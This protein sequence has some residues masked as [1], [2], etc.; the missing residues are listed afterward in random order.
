[1]S[2]Y[3][4]G[5]P[6]PSI[7]DLSKFEI[8]FGVNFPGL[9]TLPSPIFPSITMPSIEK[10][11][12]GMEMQLSQFLITIK[13]MVEPMLSLIGGDVAS[14]FPSIPSLPDF[15]LISILQNGVDGV[16][17]KIK[18]LI[19]SGFDFD[20]PLLPTLY[21]TMAIPVVKVLQTFQFIMRN[22]LVV[23]IMKI[24]NLIKQV[25]DHLEIGAAVFPSIPTPEE[26][27]A[28]MGSVIDSSIEKI[29][30]FVIYVKKHGMNAWEF[31][32]KLSFPGLPSMPET[33]GIPFDFK[34][35]E[36]TIVSDISNFLSN[37]CLGVLRKIMEFIDSTLKNYMTFTFPTICI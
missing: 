28:M 29:D 11:V 33:P 23:I 21:P 32:S 19:D 4:F 17:N 9:P 36:I 35:P 26:I 8:P 20:L 24:V 2:F 15:N 13:A 31:L 34:I 10:F 7:P 27:I 16:L 1:M 5:D 18:E 25:T 37:L 3:C 22:H 30:D 6:L 14:W 12:M